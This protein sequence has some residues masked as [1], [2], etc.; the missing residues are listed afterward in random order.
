MIQNAVFVLLIWTQMPFHTALLR[1]C[2]QRF[3]VQ[4]PALHL[5]LLPQQFAP[6]NHDENSRLYKV[7]WSLDLEAWCFVVLSERTF[8]HGTS[9]LTHCYTQILSQ[10]P[11]LWSSYSHLCGVV[12]NTHLQSSRGP[13]PPVQ[14]AWQSS[15]QSD[16]MP[17][18]PACSQSGRGRAEV[19]AGIY[20]VLSYQMV[21]PCDVTPNLSSRREAKN[22]FTQLRV[23]S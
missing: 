8:L 23:S 11:S 9:S 21:P 22:V 2:T 3:H 14:T 6:I 16:S 4:T 18:Q 12:G 15:W 1:C 7:C 19:T 5:A 17:T 20:S 13:E 10:I